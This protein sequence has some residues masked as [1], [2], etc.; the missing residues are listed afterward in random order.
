MFRV[1]FLL[2]ILI[3]VFCLYQMSKPVG[4]NRRVASPRTEAR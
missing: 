2:I 4:H 1:A 3:M